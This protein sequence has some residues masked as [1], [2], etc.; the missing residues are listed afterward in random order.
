MCSNNLHEIHSIVGHCSNLPFSMFGLDQKLVT[1]ILFSRVKIP[2]PEICSGFILGKAVLCKRRHSYS[3][4]GVDTDLIKIQ[5]WKK[6]NNSM[7]I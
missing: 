3:E 4:Y 1:S 5:V 7:Q 2:F 6:V